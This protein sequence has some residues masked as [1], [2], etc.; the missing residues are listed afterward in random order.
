MSAP[1]PSFRRTALAIVA[2]AGAA[3]AGAQQASS[4]PFMPVQQAGAAG[5][6]TPGAPLEFRGVMEDSDGVKFRI[7]DPAKKSGAWVKLNEREPSLDFVVKQ[8]EGS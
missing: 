1:L 6:P 4:S 5:A 3:R 2:L 8:H 7:V